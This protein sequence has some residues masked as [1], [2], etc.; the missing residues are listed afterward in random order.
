MNYLLSLSLA[1]EINMCKVSLSQQNC[2]GKG[3]REL[4]VAFG[5]MDNCQLKC[6]FCYLDLHW[7]CLYVCLYHVPRFVLLLSLVEGVTEVRP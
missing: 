5:N 7:I 1:E 6:I 2:G 4:R 3:L